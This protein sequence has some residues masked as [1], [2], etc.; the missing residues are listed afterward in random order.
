MVLMLR[1]HGNSW[2][3]DADEGDGYLFV[4]MFLFY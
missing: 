4:F 2:K 1:F 3:P